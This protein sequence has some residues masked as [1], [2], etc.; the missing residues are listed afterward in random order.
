VR[1]TTSTY[2]LMMKFPTEEGVGEVRGDQLAA[3]RCYNISMKKVSDPTTLTVASVFE[4][5][6]KLAEPL[7]EVVVGEGKVL[8]I[9]TCLT[10][11]VREGLMDFLCRNM[12][13]FAWSHADMPR[14]SPED[15]VH[16]LNVDPGMKPVKQK[17]RKFASKRVEAIAI[18]VE[19]L[20]KGQ[21]IQ[22]IYYPD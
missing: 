17:R 9:R 11:E 13:V 19:K 12:E 14:I 4:A 10:Q 5:K 3:R 22:E 18:K 21:F 6:G 7:E 2:H 20:L 16:V 8:Q 1:A 15:I